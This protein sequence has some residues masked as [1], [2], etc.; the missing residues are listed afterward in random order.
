MLYAGGGGGI[1]AD[2]GVDIALSVYAGGE[3]ST[4]PLIG[5][6]GARA[7]ASSLAADFEGIGI[8]L[9]NRADPLEMVTPTLSLN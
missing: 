4:L 7:E 6:S 9:G 3:S 8:V 2:D 5:V 1:G